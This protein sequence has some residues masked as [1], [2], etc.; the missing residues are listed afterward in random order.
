VERRLLGEDFDVGDLDR[1]QPHAPAAHDLEHGLPRNRA[2]K[3]AVR[4]DVLHLH[5]GNLCVFVHSLMI[6]P[7]LINELAGQR[8]S[9]IGIFFVNECQ[10]TVKWH[11]QQQR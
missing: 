6:T 4:D 9:F 2:D 11:R 3:L 8:V 1:L 10:F 5:V 7:R